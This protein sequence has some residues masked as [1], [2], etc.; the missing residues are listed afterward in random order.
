MNPDLLEPLFGVLATLILPFWILM[1]LLPSWAASRRVI[2]SLWS[3]VPIACAYV[4]LVLPQLTAV[5]PDLL[6]PDPQR[7]ASY[8]STPQGY[9]AISAHAVSLDL[10][11]GRWVYLDGYNSGR[12]A[13]LMSP[14][15]LLVMFLGP[16]GLLV[17]LASRRIRPAA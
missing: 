14:V 1:V 12:P 13:W 9:L 15:L 5:L 2:G 17:Y 8:F 6:S 4:A 16:L 11:V 3:I 10:F 7:Q